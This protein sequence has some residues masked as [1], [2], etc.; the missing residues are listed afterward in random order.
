M[1]YLKVVLCFSLLRQAIK[2]QRRYSGG[3]YEKYSIDEKKALAE[4]VVK[5]CKIEYDAYEKNN[6]GNHI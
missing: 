3:S 5:R 1:C 4:E 2:N 6:D